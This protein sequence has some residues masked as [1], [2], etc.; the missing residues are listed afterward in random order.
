[1]LVGRIKYGILLRLSFYKRI[2]D[3]A[4]YGNVLDLKRRHAAGLLLTGAALVLFNLLL[5][6]PC[7]VRKDLQLHLN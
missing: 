1:M 6:Q 2:N 7:F 4:T 5:G 3:R